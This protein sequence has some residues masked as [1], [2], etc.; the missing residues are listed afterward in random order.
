MMRSEQSEIDR[1][2]IEMREMKAILAVQ[3]KLIEALTAKQ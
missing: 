1:L 3:T 2:K